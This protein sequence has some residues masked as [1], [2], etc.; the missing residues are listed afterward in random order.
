M[1]A[2][3]I[4]LVFGN[5]TLAS[6]TPRPSLLIGKV[7]HHL[8]LVGENTLAGVHCVLA[9]DASG[10]LTSATLALG[11]SVALVNARNRNEVA[12]CWNVAVC[13]V[14]GSPFFDLVVPLPS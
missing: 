3:F 14:R 12:A 11:F 9:I 4:S 7:F 10:G 2:F 5:R 1:V 13:L 8:L 6:R